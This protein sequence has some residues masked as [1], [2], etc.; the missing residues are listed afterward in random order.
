LGPQVKQFE[1][2]PEHVAHP[3]EQ[4]A[5]LEFNGMKPEVHEETHTPA[6]LIK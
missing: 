4:G 1:V 2:V 5:H 3:L 6:V